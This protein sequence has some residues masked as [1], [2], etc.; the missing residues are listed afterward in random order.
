MRSLLQQFRNA[1]LSL[2][3]KF[4]EMFQH[5]RKLFSF[6]RPALLPVRSIYTWQRRD[7]RDLPRNVRH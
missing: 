3:S 6:N 7:P 2:T 5:M 4:R 1:R